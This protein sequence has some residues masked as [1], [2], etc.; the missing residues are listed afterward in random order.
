MI[1]GGGLGVFSPDEVGPIDVQVRSGVV[2]IAVDDEAEAVAAAK[3]YLSFFQ[4]PLHDV[5]A[6]RPAH[7]AHDRP[8][9]P[10]AHV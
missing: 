10:A 3:H 8:R 2:D 1:E 4:G 6:R 7:A 9:Q 5:G